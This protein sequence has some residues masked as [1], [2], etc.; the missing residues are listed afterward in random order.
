MD[1]T[2]NAKMENKVKFISRCKSN[3]KSCLALGRGGGGRGAFCYAILDHS[4]SGERRERWL[5]LYGATYR[6]ENDGLDP[7]RVKQRLIVE[8]LNRDDLDVGYEERWEFVQE[9]GPI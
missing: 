1:R 2:Q 4:G 8:F 3:S 7:M 5:D 6:E 9:Y